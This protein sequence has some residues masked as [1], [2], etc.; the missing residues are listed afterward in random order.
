[1]A[2]GRGTWVALV[3]FAA[4]GGGALVGMQVRGGSPAGVEPTTAGAPT[5]QGRESG[6]GDFSLRDLIGTPAVL[7]FYRG[8][9]C[10]LCLQRLGAL[11]AHAAAY[12]RA[13]A[14]VVAVTGESLDAARNTADEVGGGVRIVAV[15]EA[16]LRRWGVWPEGAPAPMPAEFVL[17][18]NGAVLFGHVGRSA[19]ES[20]GDVAL[21]GVLSD[22]LAQRRSAA[23]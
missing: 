22:R 12:E 6:G 9:H 7:V 15:D 1:M 20:A 21:L 14:R 4:L 13:G 3:A 19:A 23:R 17:D 10:P 16:T 8:G 18:E 2:A 5:L 11:E